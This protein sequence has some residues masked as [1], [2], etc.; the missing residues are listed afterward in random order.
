LS[1][2]AVR[3]I[4]QNRFKPSAVGGYERGERAISLDRFCD[5]C[6][7]Y[8]VAPE[9]TLARAMG[10]RI[11]IV[12]SVGDLK[13]IRSPAPAPVEGIAPARKRLQR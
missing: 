8:G 12:E 5:L 9:I 7:I 1:L 2:R 3:V 10:H 11:P 6:S 4:S 13:V